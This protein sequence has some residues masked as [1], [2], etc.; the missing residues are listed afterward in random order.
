MRIQAKLFIAL[1]A[2]IGIVLFA[3][4]LRTWYSADYLRFSAYLLTA[5]LA[6]GL[7]ITLPGTDASM[8]VNFLFTLLGVLE[9][10]P[11]ET[12]IIGCGPTL[13]QCLRQR[14]QGTG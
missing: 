7:K 5:L 11:A 6:S 12:M 13:V 1:T 2:T 8:S 4:S 9:L 14:N 10:S 3:L